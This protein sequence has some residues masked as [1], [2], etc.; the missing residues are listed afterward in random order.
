MQ[1]ARDPAER[2]ARRLATTPRGRAAVAG[3]STRAGR[4]DAVG[5]G[6]VAPHA[7]GQA[8]E[9]GG[10]ERRRL[11]DRRHLDRSSGGVGERLGERRV[12]AHPAVD[13]QRG[14]RQAGVGLGRLD[15]VGAAVGDALEHGPHDVGARSC[16][17]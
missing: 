10:A 16:P 5:V 14:D 12:G 2:R 13:P 15:Q 1:T 4:H 9:E 3:S 6:D 7:D 17:G 8:G 11:D